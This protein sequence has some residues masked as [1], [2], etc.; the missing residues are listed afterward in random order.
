MNPLASLSATTAPADRSAAPS[1]RPATLVVRS[2]LCSDQHHGSVVP[3]IHLSSNFTFA[4][5]GQARTYD[6]TRS[7]N[8][9]RDL[10]ATA[11]AD[12]EGGAGA[13]VTSTGMS[14]IHLV[15]QLLRPGDLVVAAHDC[16]GGTHRLLSSCS[17]RGDFRVIFADLTD[18]LRRDA[19]LRTGPRL[20]WVET[21]SNPLLRITDVRAICRGAAAVGALV[22]VDNTFLS[23]ALQRPLELGADLVV[24]STTKYLNGHS[25]VVG[26]AVVARD[27]ALHGD[28]AWWANCLGLT[29]APFDS[30]LTLRG[31]R[32]LHARVR[33]HLENAAA[34]VEVL[35]CHPAV[36]K[37]HYPG[38]PDHPG[39]ALVATQ[40]HGFGAMVSCEL[41][42]G[43]PA[44]RAFLGGL[45]HFA[46]AESLGGVESLVAHPATMTHASMGA[47]ARRVAGIGEGLLRLSVGIE[48]AGDL[49]ADLGAGLER[50]VVAVEREAVAL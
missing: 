1:A 11:L 45:R 34:V 5:F 27:A 7:G 24:H 15:L 2:G 42:G 6:Y 14:A 40:Q 43:E 47:E 48:D 36:A 30:Y 33:V 10:L 18:P 21:P 22:A 46:L 28:L 35:R 49:C 9:T 4:G 37:V 13:V 8:P 26:G 16:Y 20:V 39:H 38:L 29:G 41:A 3:P 23:P 17:E 32:T 12:A 50:A 44:V 25:D 19:A 31:L